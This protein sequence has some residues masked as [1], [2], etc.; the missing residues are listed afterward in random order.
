MRN[1]RVIIFQ[2][3]FGVVFRFGLLFAGFAYLVDGIDFS[4]LLDVI[5]Q[6]D[7]NAL[8]F[9]LCFSLIF[10]VLLGYRLY[11]LSQRRVNI[12]FGT[13]ATILGHGFNNILP[14][15]LGE[16]VKAYYI[17]LKTGVSKAESLSIV[18]W[19][20]FLDLNIALLIALVL[21][22]QSEVCLA[23]LP[24]AIGI[25]CLWLVL[26]LVKRWGGFTKIVIA[27][28]PFVKIQKMLFEIHGHIDNRFNQK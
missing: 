11:T 17:S 19:E 9:V 13:M 5:D 16:L 24:L 26:V 20:R 15:K 4:K 25:C 3:I 10:Y 18:F 8:I 12:Y 28:I 21:V 27:N 1:S 14:S 6:Y 2:H 22:Y 7:L 23:T